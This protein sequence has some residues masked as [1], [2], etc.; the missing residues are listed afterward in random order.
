MMRD[1]FVRFAPSPTGFLHLGNAR[2]AALNF[3]FARHHK[4]RFVLRLDD[5]DHTRARAEYKDAIIEDLAWLGIV[6]DQ[7]FCQSER[8]AA[9]QKAADQLKA[10]GRLYP[11]YESEQ[12]LALARRQARAAGRPPVYDRAALALTAA[13]KQAFEDDED[14]GRQPHWRFKLS[15]EICSFDDLLR[16][17]VKVQTASLSDPVLIRADGRFLYTLPSVLDDLDFNISDVI[18]GEDHLTNTAVH[19][20]LAE[21]LGGAP[22]RF[23]HHPLMTDHEGA[24]LSKRKGD[25][26]LRALKADGFE[27]ETLLHFLIG[28]DDFSRDLIRNFDFAKAASERIRFDQV[29]L[30]RLNGRFLHELDGAVAAPRLAAM[31]ISGGASFWEAVRR[32]LTR[33]SDARLWW[34][35]LDD[36]FSGIASDA[37]FLA[38]AARLLPPAPWDDEVWANWTRA[39]GAATG[40]RGR[41]LYLPLR[42]ALTGR[43]DGPEMKNL[44]LLLGY[45]RVLAR[46]NGRSFTSS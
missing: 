31:G 26:S 2:T 23:A 38:E 27:P 29:H 7:T 8:G 32:N 14:D 12:E 43:E 11:C 25:L 40:R 4:G 28:D 39:L 44:I 30:L 17:A 36:D 3:L 10:S 20:E 34:E 33:F 37:A 35:L 6:P 1:I 46:L 9:Y 45:D 19:V 13:Q 18:R 16:G 5:T 22:P 42:L 21:A 24:S 15:G 41:E